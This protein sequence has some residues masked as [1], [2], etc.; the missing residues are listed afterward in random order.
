VAYILGHPVEI[1]LQIWRQHDTRVQ[2]IFSNAL[3]DLRSCD[4]PSD[5]PMRD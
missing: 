5:R 1:G 2:P 4:V 3:Q